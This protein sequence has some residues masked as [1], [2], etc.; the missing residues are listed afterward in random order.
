MQKQNKDNK[1]AQIRYATRNERKEKKNTKLIVSSNA[2][3]FT[4]FIDLWG[5]GGME[6]LGNAKPGL[7]MH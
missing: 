3:F 1:K 4:I 2:F 5:G 6:R 7:Y